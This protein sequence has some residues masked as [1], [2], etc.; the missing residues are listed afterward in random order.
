MTLADRMSRVGSSPTQQVLLEANRLAR[1]GVDVVDLG[2]GEPD[3]S[4]P[5]HVK[6]AGAAAIAEDFTKYTPNAGIAELK[7]AICNWYAAKYGVE[8]VQGEAIVTAG[9]KQA[10]FNVAMA[11]F[12]PGDEIITH[13]PGWPSIVDQIKLSGAD[14]VLVRTFPDEKFSVRAERVLEAVTPR[15][16]AIVIN[17]PSNPTG[18][19]IT[20]ADLECIAR[21]TEAAGIWLVIDLCYEQLIYDEV[22]HNLPRVLFESARDRAVIAGS[23]SKSYAMTGWRCGWA[24]GPTKFIAGANAVQS[25]STSSVSSI[26]QRAAVVALSGSQTAVAEML[27][28]YRVRRDQLIAWLAEE[29]RIKVVRPAG[30][31]YLFPD[32][33]ELLSPEG[34][35][36][37]ASFATELLAR[38]HVAVTAGEAFDA[39]GFLRISYATSLSRLKDGIDR[40]KAFIAALDS[41]DK[42]DLSM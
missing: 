27:R 41:R 34:V 16:R 31:F 36:T 6:A 4:T 35:R 13:V 29:P 8:Y 33:S 5:D 7:E 28:E 24:L 26:T 23:V 22:S 14:P 21:E 19:L 1:Q 11:L 30:A 42:G 3:F 38:S 40:L 10:L 15:T 17:S 18:A 12:G 39:P 9:G 25:H 37:S 2:A 32:I 20:E